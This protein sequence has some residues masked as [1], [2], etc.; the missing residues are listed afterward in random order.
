MENQINETQIDEVA[1]VLEENKSAEDDRIM[2]SAKKNALEEHVDEECVKTVSVDPQSGKPIILEEEDTDQYIFNDDLDIGQVNDGELEKNNYEKF[3][4]ALVNTAKKSSDISDE[5]AVKLLNTIS[6]YT[7]GEKPSKLLAT[8][9]DEFKK[10]VNDLYASSQGQ[11]SKSKILAFLLDNFIAE[12]NLEKEIVDFQTTMEKTLDI[13][14]IIDMYSEHIKEIMEEKTLESADRLEAAGEKDKADLLRKVSEA[15][16]DTYTFRSLRLHLHNDRKARNHITK[17]VKNYTKFCRNFNLK[18]ES[19]KFAINDVSLMA[20]ILV[21][22]LDISEESAKKFVILFCKRCENLS[23]SDVVDCAYMYYFI[24]N[25]L[26]L[27]YINEAKTD[28]SVNLIKSID[29]MIN[30]IIDVEV[31]HNAEIA[32]ERRKKEEKKNKRKGGK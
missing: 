27:D 17:D 9:P 1:K 2:E 11:M 6:A 14:S 30:E 12:A 8:L 25:I 4:N 29:D 13:P 23:S 19:S 32:L 24:K 3:K 26:T 20:P 15:F 16:T 22:V 28:F 7:K 31:K 21:R 18:N 5:S 10:M